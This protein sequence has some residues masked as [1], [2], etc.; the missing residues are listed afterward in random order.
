MFVAVV[1]TGV[2]VA[3]PDLQ[4][5]MWVNPAE[6]SGI[7]GVDDDGNGYIDD[8]HGWDFFNENASVYDDIDDWHGTHVA[9]T[10]GARGDN[11]T[12]VAGVNWNVSIIPVK[13]I[14]RDQSGDLV[15]SVAD[16]VAALGY[17]TDLKQRH[18]LN[19]VAINASWGG[20][21]FSQTLLEAVNQAGNQGILVVAA[22]GNGGV[23]FV[24]DNND[25]TPYYPASFSCTSGGARSWDCMLS[26][27]NITSSGVLSGSSNYGATSVDLGA[28]G[29]GIWSTYPGSYAQASGTSMAAPHVTGAVALCASLDS[30]LG[31]A[32][33]TRSSARIRD[34]HH[35]ARG[36][37]R[38]G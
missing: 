32:A 1:D 36:R 13:F 18:G 23:D 10:I 15:G 7:P 2:Q 28:P 3:H 22:A 29:S 9:G 30:S 25:A 20:A 17:V 5:N 31:P 19:V 35:C 33:L 21:G 6:S 16:A 27:A 37:D 4:P 34:L 11:G 8:I 14:D 26:V 12:G 38:H 24:G